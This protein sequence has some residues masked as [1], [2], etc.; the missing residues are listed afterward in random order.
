MKNEYEAKLARVGD[1]EER[2]EQ[3][4][5]REAEIVHLR[6]GFGQLMY[7]ASQTKTSL[8]WT[9]YHGTLGLDPSWLFDN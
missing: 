4:A 8:C 5:L 3:L 6:D 7:N 9:Q 1:V 2:E